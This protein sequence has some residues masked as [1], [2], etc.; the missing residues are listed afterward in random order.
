MHKT[1]IIITIAFIVIAALLV[2]CA[3]EEEQDTNSHRIFRNN[4]D[5]INTVNNHPRASWKARVYPQLEGKL[6]DSLVGV[7]LGP[8]EYNTVTTKQLSVPNDVP[9]NFDSATQW[10]TCI[11]GIR[12]QGQ[13]A[14]CWAMSSS[15][16]L[17]DRFCIASYGSV[18]HVLSPQYQISCDESSY[19]CQGALLSNVWRFLSQQGTVTEQCFPY[20][21]YTGNVPEC[22]YNCVPGGGPMKFYRVRSDSIRHL[23]MYDLNAVQLDILSHGPLQT[24]FRVYQD[25]YT[26]SS[27][28]YRYV[29]T[30]HNN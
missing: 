23:S 7:Q 18:N 13:C 28:V 6:I 17:S 20:Q 25:F 29:V 15:E 21:S 1:Q 26:Y 16:V 2:N 10:P 3:H 5:I 4:I 14:S 9:K 12:D 19:G 11:H 27:G 30:F 8:K 22:R 24:G